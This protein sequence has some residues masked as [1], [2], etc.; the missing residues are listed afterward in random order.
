LPPGKHKRTGERQLELYDR[1]RFFVTTGRMLTQF[2]SSIEQR[3]A[4][5]E[6]LLAAEFSYKKRS[7]KPRRERYIGGTR[8]DLGRV[9]DEGNVEVFTEIADN[10]AEV[11][12]GVRCPWSKAH[13]EGD[14]SGT[15]VLQYPSGATY[16]V[17][18]HA[19]CSH[20][21]WRDFYRAV[22]SVRRAYDFT[23][24]SISFER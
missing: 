10:T 13:S 15:R 14:V 22:R 23:E 21:A 16:F 4:E 9:L 19:H 5:V 6:A 8:L 3:Q 1:R 18:E 20:R 17:C 2:S 24:V 11:A 12:F 7:H